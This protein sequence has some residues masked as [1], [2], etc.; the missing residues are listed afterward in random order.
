[1]QGKIPAAAS[2]VLKSS[3]FVGGFEGDPGVTSPISLEKV[4]SLKGPIPAPTFEW[5]VFAQIL[6]R[7]PPL[8]GFAP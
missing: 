7:C 3:V 8:D 2:V 4:A 1:M 6:L 5:Q